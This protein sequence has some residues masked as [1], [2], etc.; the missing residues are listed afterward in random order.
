MTDRGPLHVVPNPGYVPSPAQPFFSGLK[1]E[2][3]NQISD[4]TSKTFLIGEYATLTDPGRTV[5]W[6]SSWYGFNLG[7][8]VL[9]Y[10]APNQLQQTQ[11]NSRY[12]FIPDY[13]YCYNNYGNQ[14]N[15]PCARAF[16]SLHAGGNTMNFASCDGSVHPVSNT[17]DLVVLGNLVTI[18]GGESA[19]LP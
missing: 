15:D 3:L 10:Y 16:A 12:Q 17:I 14:F 5:F 18:A 8:V 6:A 1:A 7:T 9:H 2:R 13:T 19:T 11:I 4:G